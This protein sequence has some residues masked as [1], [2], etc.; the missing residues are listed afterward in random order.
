MIANCDCELRLAI[1][2]LVVDRCHANFTS[3]PKSQPNSQSQPNPNSPKKSNFI[4]SKIQKEKHKT[5][6]INFAVKKKLIIQQKSRLG[7]LKF[8]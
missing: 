7:Y 3:H 4:T 6:N 1:A 2:S 5:Q 8:E